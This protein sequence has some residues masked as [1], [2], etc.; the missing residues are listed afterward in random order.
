MSENWTCQFCN[1][2]QV[3]LED[4]ESTFNYTLGFGKTRHG[5]LR[6]SGQAMRCANDECEEITISAA[7]NEAKPYQGVP[8][9]NWP[10]AKT[11]KTWR[12]IPE[13]S[14]K[15]Q[16]DYIPQPI[17]Q[18]YYEACL[19]VDKS[20]K[21]SAT[22]VRRCLQGM[23]RDFCGIAKSRLIDEIRE[24]RNR[25][26]RGE[27]PPGVSH[28]SV[29]AIDAVRDI[30]NIGAHMEKD[31]GVIIDVDPDEAQI[32]IEL[33]EQLLD[34]WYV[35][36]HTRQVRLD[37][38]KSLAQDKKELKTPAVTTEAPAALIEVPKQ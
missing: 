15:P 20:P 3:L 35:E 11:I 18:D 1:H 26:D 8:E 22:L 6:F 7:L 34:E 28:E 19:I 37:R 38:I 24:L 23:I 9:Y 2:A 12:L 27:S 31:I 25:M 21:A 13:S 4:N 17:R 10:I 30:G 33:V 5:Y 36:R 16:P 32:L 29:D 14:S